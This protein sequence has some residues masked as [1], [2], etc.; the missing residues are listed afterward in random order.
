[1]VSSCDSKPKLKPKKTTKI[2][3]PP[4]E[5]NADSA[6]SYIEK[7][8]SFGPRVP[9]TKSHQ[10]CRDWLVYKLRAYGAK[11]QLQNAEVLAYDGKVL[12]ISN[13]IASYNPAAKKRIF[14]CAHWDT[15]PIADQD[16][17]NKNKAIPGAN[18]GGSGVGVLLEIARQLQ[19]DSL[20]LGV[21]IILFD[22]EDYGAPRTSPKAGTAETW[23][24]GSQ[25][26]SRHPHNPSYNPKYGILLDMVG[27][28]NASFA[29]EQNS[30][31]Y[32]GQVMKRVWK[33]A[34]QLGHGSYFRY[35]K[36]P[37]IIDDHLFINEIANFPCIDI[38][39]H[40]TYSKSSFGD[41]W[42]THDDNLSIIDK[43]TLNA[44]GESVMANVKC[45]N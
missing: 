41:Y 43:S 7:Q 21:D 44:V 14:L 24:L 19:K 42:H 15:R 38:V 32:A 17:E 4:F 25:Y 16:D 27:A 45:E 2:E 40:D 12:N 37:P 8:L 33:I 26:W 13:I 11:V 20:S 31:N 28:R 5:F 1:L 35:D 34:H 30:L 36:V 6:Y 29:M 18:D 22:A 10:S 23:C 3:I 39:H 9:N